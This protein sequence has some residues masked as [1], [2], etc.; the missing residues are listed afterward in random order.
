MEDSRSVSGWMGSQEI[1]IGKILTVDEVIAIVDAIT[2]EE[3]KKVAGDIL[4][5]EKLRLAAVGP[6]DPDGPWEELLKI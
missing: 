1:L 2:V 6:I 4:L 5:G 3:L